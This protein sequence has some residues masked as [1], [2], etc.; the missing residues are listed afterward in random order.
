MVVVRRPATKNNIPYLLAL[1]EVGMRE[2]AEALWGDWTTQDGSD[3]DVSAHEIIEL[4][5]VA[6]GCVATDW[7]VDH[8]LSTSSTSRPAFNGRVLAH[9]SLE[10]KLAQAAERGVPTMLSVLT[11]NP[12]DWFYRREGFELMSETAERLL[13]SRP[14]EKRKVAVAASPV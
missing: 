8:L 10:R 13:S 2:Y 9:R 5:G 7:D 4:D 3:L 12:A 1:E 6:V 11:T 14:G